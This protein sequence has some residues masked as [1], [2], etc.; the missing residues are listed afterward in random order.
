MVTCLRDSFCVPVLRTPFLYILVVEQ[1]SQDKCHKQ[2]SDKQLCGAAFVSTSTS[3]TCRGTANFP[4][5]LSAAEVA[6]RR[7]FFSPSLTPSDPRKKCRRREAPGGRPFLRGDDIVLSIFFS[8]RQHHF[9]HNL[10]CVCLFIYFFLYSDPLT[11]SNLCSTLCL[12]DISP[13]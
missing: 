7:C 10:S 12:R 6:R 5:R 9:C 2:V 1:E 3:D 8:P 4:G 11:V 13:S